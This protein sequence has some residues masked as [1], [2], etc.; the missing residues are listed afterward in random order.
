MECYD[1]EKSPATSPELQEG[2]KKRDD[3]L[4]IPLSSAAALSSAPFPGTAL[5]HRCFQEAFHHSWVL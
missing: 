5:T 1:R 3:E 2:T 4:S